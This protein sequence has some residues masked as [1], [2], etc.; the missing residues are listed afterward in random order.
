[1]AETAARLHPFDLA[2]GP[3][4]P[5]QFEAIRLD[6][7]SS[8]V[9]PFDR[10]AWT[11]TRPVA[12][13]LRELRPDEGLGEA[14][15]ELVALAH[16]GFLFWQQ[17]ERSLVL[18]RE[19]LPRLGAARPTPA[20]APAPPTAYY[21]QAPPRR[22]WGSPVPDAPP[23]PLDGWFAAAS[24]DALAIV[25]VFGLLPGRPGF[26]VAHVR[27]PVPGPMAR[28][29]GTSIFAPT[30]PGGEAAD[31]WSLV[32]QEELLELG[33]RTHGLVAGGTP[34]ASSEEPSR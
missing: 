28:E 10:D 19:D 29:D 12:E 6:L 15:T 1:M 20:G 17:G 4:V 8:G 32:G 11:L 22:I 13:L 16:A 26:T 14:V 2:L 5:E 30:M 31:L 21:L 18:G 33:W 9:D 25:A 3:F 23:E 27:G 7:A 34:S 24:G